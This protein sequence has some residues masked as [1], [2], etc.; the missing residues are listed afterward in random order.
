VAIHKKN[1]TPPEMIDIVVDGSNNGNNEKY[2]I[3]Y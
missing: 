2:Q 1:R 3:K